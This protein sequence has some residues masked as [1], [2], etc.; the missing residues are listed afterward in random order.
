MC[1]FPRFSYQLIWHRANIS[2]WPVGSDHPGLCVLIC[3]RRRLFPAVSHVVQINNAVGGPV[4]SQLTAPPFPFI[5][6]LLI[7]AQREATH[8]SSSSQ[9]FSWL[10]FISLLK[11]REDFERHLIKWPSKFNNLKSGRIYWIFN[12]INE[13][14]NYYYSLSVAMALQL[15]F[16]NFNYPF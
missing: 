16:V 4:S 5:H 6:Q 1:S 2:M 14:S 15:F 8:P 9:C 11:S 12:D 10:G 7:N 3:K 13:L